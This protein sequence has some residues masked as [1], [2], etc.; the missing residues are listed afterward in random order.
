MEGQHEGLGHDNR[1]TVL[2]EGGPNVGW[3]REMIGTRSRT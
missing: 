2:F 3:N 1:V